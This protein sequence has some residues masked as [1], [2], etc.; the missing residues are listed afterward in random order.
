[1]SI[2][3]IYYVS[4]N[5]FI[6]LNYVILKLNIKSK[7]IHQTDGLIGVKGSAESIKINF[8]FGNVFWKCMLG[9]LYNNKT[10]N[11]FVQLLLT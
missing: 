3:N 8:F 5:K 6:K 4:N 9:H 2:T 10:V 11:D 7:F 1:M